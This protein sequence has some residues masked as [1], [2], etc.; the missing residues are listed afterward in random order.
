MDDTYRT[1]LGF[2][3]PDDPTVARVKRIVDRV[4]HVRG[5]LPK[6]EPYIES[7]QNFMTY[8]NG[9]EIQESGVK[10][11]SP[12]LP[13][14]CPFHAGSAP[15]DPQYQVPLMKVGDAPALDLKVFSWEEVRQHNTED[16][17][18]VV[19]NGEVYDVSAFASN[20]PGGLKVLLNGNGRDMTK[21][22]EKANHTY[23]TKVF[24]LNFRIG[25]I[26]PGP[27]PP[28]A[29]HVPVAHANAPAH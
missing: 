22:F 23:L 16:D 9:V 26:E 20:H 25:R 10:E 27:P 19:F 2:E 3:M 14:A 6:G 21:A 17:L 4:T 28:A 5:L 13:R 15:I 29:R 11:R 7:L 24:A 12:R 8:P 1:A 18:W